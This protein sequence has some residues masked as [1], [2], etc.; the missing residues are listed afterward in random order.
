MKKMPTREDLIIFLFVLVDDFL[1]TF[2]LKKPGK[3]PIIS[4]SELFTMSVLQQLYHE[5]SEAN[6]IRSYVPQLLSFF[7]KLPSLKEYNRRLRENQEVLSSIWKLMLELFEVELTSKEAYIDTAPIAVTKHCRRPKGD[8]HPDAALGYCATKDFWFHGY[9]LHL[10]VSP[11]GIPL[12][13]T[14]LSADVDET[15]VLRKEFLEELTGYL[16]GGDKGYLISDE[17]KQELL[18][19]LGLTLFHPYR[20]NQKKKNTKEEKAFLK[21]RGIIEKV[22]SWNERMLNLET[23]LAKTYDGVAS[24]YGENFCFSA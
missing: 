1:K 15:G 19:N 9:F 2:P 18:S 17:K 13:F 16:L 11:K 8:F 24:E 10:V 5:E 4:D 20:R 3:H 14:I 21:E 23:T 22:F 12:H 7:G 6:F